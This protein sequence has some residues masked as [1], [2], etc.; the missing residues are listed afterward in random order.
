MFAAP[1][2]QGCE[3]I[4]RRHATCKFVCREER[5]KVTCVTCHMSDS[6]CGVHNKN[7]KKCSK[8]NIV[9][10]NNTEQRLEFQQPRARYPS[11]HHPHTHASSSSLAVTF[12]VTLQSSHSS[13]RI[14]AAAGARSGPAHWYVPSAAQSFG[15]RFVR[16]HHLAIISS[17]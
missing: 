5:Q 14:C 10:R 8:K 13:P 6:F 4:G 12:I 7:S 15:R 3:G 1:N 16:R 9:F 17:A 11:N 2:G